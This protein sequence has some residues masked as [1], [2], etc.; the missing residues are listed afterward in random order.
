[1]FC[2]LDCN[3]SFSTDF[4]HYWWL[5]KVKKNKRNSPSSLNS[6]YYFFFLFAYEGL[7]FKTK[8]EVEFWPLGKESQLVL[9]KPLN[10]YL[11]INQKQPRF[12]FLQMFVK[13]GRLKGKKEK[14]TAYVKEDYSKKLQVEMFSKKNNSTKCKLLAKIRSHNEKFYS[15][16]GIQFAYTLANYFSKENNCKHCKQWQSYQEKISCFETKMSK[17][18]VYTYFQDQFLW[19]NTF[20]GLILKLILL[21]FCLNEVYLKCTSVSKYISKFKRSTPIRR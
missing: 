9:N 21:D 4:L 5:L 6:F 13:K 14:S 10:G 16:L 8:F 3:F 15:L 12:H 20:C 11:N 18:Y 2:S 7:S 19:V 17:T 1:M